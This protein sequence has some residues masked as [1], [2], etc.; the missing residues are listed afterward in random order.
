MHPRYP[1]L[2]GSKTRKSA[3]RLVI[4]VM[5]FAFLMLSVQHAP[6]EGRFDDLLYRIPASANAL[7]VLDVKAIH[8]SPLAVREGWRDQHQA[9]FVTQPLI[10][11]PESDRLVLASQMNPNQ[12]FAQAWELAV[13]SL[14]ESL[15]MQ[16]IAKAEGGY[17]D[18][19]GG[20]SAAWTPSDAYFV[21]FDS[22][23]MG[24]MHPAHRQAIS[25]WAAYSREN[26][27]VNI[28]P[29]L[30]QAAGMVDARTQI[31]MAIDLTDVVQPHELQEGVRESEFT[32]DDAAK[33]REW[34]R[35][36][37]GVQGL[38]LKVRLGESARGT[39]QVDFS[40]RTSPFAKQAKALV[41]N[42]LEKYGAGIDEM[43]QWKASLH[44]NSIALEGPLTTSAMR[45]LFSLLE[46][47]TS[48]FSTLKDE[49][50]S[51]VDDTQSVA[52]VSR[53]YFKSVSTLLDDLRNEFRTNR[54]ARRSFSATYM[55][56]YGRRIDRLPILNVDEELLA[57]GAN[58]SETLRNVSVAK[59]MSGV[60]TGVRKSQTYG[61]YSYNYRGSGYYS[62]RSSANARTTVQRQ[63][64]ATASK[65]RF[66]SWKEIEDATAAIRVEMTQRYN[67][68]F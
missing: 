7:M 41:L 66:E 21:S 3:R 24:V 68:E 64:Q 30:K 50:P 15:S 28:S 58:V 39:L 29:Y 67:V 59:R 22:K 20:L 37:S 63:E 42:T 16:S 33:Q 23:T 62:G 34:F 56:R 4:W 32:R 17:V 27:K 43:H 1:Q 55:E 25:R 40:E 54:D 53:I 14:T 57:Y 36:I 13:M 35:I 65:I 46:L 18:K 49:S 45:K 8:R 12:G 47:P 6:A 11:P 31:V 2:S 52:R 9:N 48:K 19:I 51:D 44:G 5:T 10:L 38:T 26:R 60:R 61:S